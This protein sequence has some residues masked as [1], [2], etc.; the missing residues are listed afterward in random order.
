MDNLSANVPSGAIAGLPEAS[1]SQG[2]N[3]FPKP[4]A[5][6]S[7]VT[8]LEEGSSAAAKVPKQTSDFKI[9]KSDDIKPY[10]CTHFKNNCYKKLVAVLDQKTLLEI[11][12]EFSND[13]IRLIMKLGRY[14]DNN[15]HYFNQLKRFNLPDDHHTK[16]HEEEL[17]KFIAMRRENNP[18]LFVLAKDIFLGEAG[19]SCRLEDE[20]GLYFAPSSVWLT[21]VA[22]KLRSLNCERGI[23]VMG[24][25][26]YLSYFLEK[27][28]FSMVVSDNH[29]D[30][31]HPAAASP[32][33]VVRNENSLDTVVKHQQ[34]ADFLAISWP[35]PPKNIPALGEY[36]L[37]EMLD[38]Y[39]ILKT[40]GVT[41]P[42]L[43]IGERPSPTTNA[44]GSEIFHQHLQMYF[45]ACKIPEYQGRRVGSLDEAIIF[46]PNGKQ[47]QTANADDIQQA[48][49]EGC[50]QQ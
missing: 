6:E 26:G 18:E 50:K 16:G 8:S 47:M 43:F 34:S 14:Q 41:K 24:G 48:L 25:K 28:G 33:I 45:D 35:P 36:F 17:N 27:Y 32:P 10:D 9:T 2:D 1:P 44:T 4:I 12:R 39:Q 11:M 7:K 38:D 30:Y 15:E 46:V 22:E 5:V 23:E 37:R 19:G 40:W 13:D 20:F 31:Q 42:V 21:P 3:S 29:S 49:E